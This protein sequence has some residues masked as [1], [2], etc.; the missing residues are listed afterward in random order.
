MKIA[1][2]GGTGLVATELIRQALTITEITSIIVVARR[3]VQLDT[4][5][6]NTSKFRS[7][8]L[9]DYEEFTDAV[10]AEL[11]GVDVCIWTVAVTPFR[12]SKF[13]FVEVK[14]VCQDCT[15]AGLQAVSEVNHAA[16]PTAFIYMSAE[17]T[18]EDL[19][20]KTFILGDYNLMRHTPQQ[21]RTEK[22][23]QEF[24]QEHEQVNTYIVRPG[25]VW[26]HIT[27]WRGVQ[28]NLFRVTN[29][30]TRAIPNIGRNELAA[31]ILDQAVNGFEKNQKMLSNADLVR[32][33][34][35]AVARRAKA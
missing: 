18:P 31:A 5:A 15:V 13:D 20:R 29:L 22:I 7:V 24:G 17:G 35:N 8:T 23:V 12:L 19:T 14:R 16:K 28:A 1:I 10:K 9:R 2:I 30:V 25:M 3:P 11:S 32:I 34:T 4:D 21:G 26:S 27:F 6:P 33:G